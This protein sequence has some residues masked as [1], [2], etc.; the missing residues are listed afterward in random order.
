MEFAA[1]L[2]P[3]EIREQMRPQ[4]AAEKCHEPLA[5]MWPIE[6]KTVDLLN[7]MENVPPSVPPQYFFLSSAG[8]QQRVHSCLSVWSAL[9]VDAESGPNV[10]LRH[11]HEPCFCF[12]LCR[13]L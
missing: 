5:P 1:E 12:C 6:R 13:G 11:G 3:L 10:Q 4:K 7:F 8:C 9:C 2:R